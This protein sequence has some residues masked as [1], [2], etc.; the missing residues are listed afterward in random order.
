MYLT[1]QVARRWLFNLGVAIYAKEPSDHHCKPLNL[2]YSVLTPAFSMYYL[3]SKA[4][5][6]F[7]LIAWDPK[8]IQ[9]IIFSAISAA[10][11]V[12]LLTN[13]FI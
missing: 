2:G 13:V 10:L 9:I 7:T 5:S 1:S 12:R 4:W 3:C 6:H 8:C 11:S